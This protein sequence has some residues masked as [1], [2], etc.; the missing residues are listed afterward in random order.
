[1]IAVA[2]ISIL[3]LIA[4]PSYLAHRHK[5][6]IAAVLGTAG[7][8]RAA[9]ASYASDS[10]EAH[11]PLSADIGGWEA[12]RTIANAH[13][14]TLRSPP[15]AMGIETIN[16]TSE[17]GTTYLLHIVVNV[18]QGMLGRIVAVTPGSIAR[19]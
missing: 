2:I 16:Y 13:G 3:A 4:I 5:S 15:T 7:D 17:D 8:I 19:Q 12:L 6:V 1:M 14:S 9:L 18:P 10:R 11:F